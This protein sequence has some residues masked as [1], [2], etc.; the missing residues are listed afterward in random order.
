[1]A[2][3]E[4]GGYLM[5]DLLGAIAVGCLLAYAI[6]HLWPPPRRPG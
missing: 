2:Q 3:G 6:L 4:P 1:M 5:G